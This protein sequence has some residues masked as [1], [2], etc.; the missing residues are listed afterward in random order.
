MSVVRQIG[1]LPCRIDGWIW[2]LLL[3]GLFIF[4]IK[5]HIIYPIEYV[6]HADASTGA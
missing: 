6:G 4:I 3:I 1:T 2:L 5:C